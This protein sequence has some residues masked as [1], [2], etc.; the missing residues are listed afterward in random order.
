MNSINNMMQLSN[1]AVVRLEAIDGGGVRRIEE[2]GVSRGNKWFKLDLK[3]Q[4]LDKRYL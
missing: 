1:V 4:H 3:K 2:G